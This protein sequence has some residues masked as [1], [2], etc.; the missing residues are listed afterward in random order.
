MG[1]PTT[2]AWAIPTAVAC[3]WN[4][5]LAWPPWG[6]PKGPYTLSEEMRMGEG[7]FEGGLGGRVVIRM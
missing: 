3:L 1:L 4:V 6:Y 2:G 5:L 7:R